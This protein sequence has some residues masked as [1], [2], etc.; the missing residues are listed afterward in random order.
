[1]CGLQES[2]SE[3]KLF[4]TDLYLRIKE[5]ISVGG[6]AEF[7]TEIFIDNYLI[8]IG[9]QLKVRNVCIVKAV[10]CTLISRRFFCRQGQHTLG[11]AALPDLE[12]SALALSP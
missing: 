6:G 2:S 10:A 11:Y 7:L 4:T 9:I 8:N 12:Q 3:V 5:K 1:M